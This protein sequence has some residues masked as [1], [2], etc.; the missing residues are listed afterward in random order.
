VEKDEKRYQKLTA[1]L[2]GVKSTLP[3]NYINFQAVHGTFDE[4][5]TQVFKYLDEQKKRL[6]PTFAFVDPFGFSHTPFSTIA[7]ILQNPKCEVLVNFMYEEINRFLNHPDHA[8]T[9]DALFGS[10][11]WRNALSAATSDER[12]R[13]IHSLYLNQLRTAAKYV[14]SFEML[15]DGNKT[16]YF[17]FFATNS[18]KG[19]EKMKEAMWA[20]DPSGTFQFS[21]YT[22]SLGQVSLF[23]SEPEYD[24]LRK[25]ITAEY[26]GKQI[27]ITALE[28]WVIAETPFLPRHIRKN[29]LD[30]MVNEGGVS[31]R[32]AKPNRRKGTYPEGTILK[33]S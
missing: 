28:D 9:F 10:T 30:P 2:N 14:R 23:A 29:V 32:K 13:F 12:R 5:L 4:Q 16:D 17:L 25:M 31:I 19:L 33:F 20:V 26:S 6:A 22:D 18:L 8:E 7:K 21:D 11:S 15:N 24:A 27:E 3:K 1:V